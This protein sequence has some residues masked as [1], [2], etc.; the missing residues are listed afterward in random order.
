MIFP[1]GIRHPMPTSASRRKREP[2]KCS[3][4]TNHKVAKYYAFRL[5]G[6]VP[7]K[8][9]LSRLFVFSL[10]ASDANADFSAMNFPGGSSHRGPRVAEVLIMAAVFV[11]GQ[12]LTTQKISG[13]KFRETNE[14]S[15]K[16][17]KYRVLR[18]KG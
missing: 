3:P 5:K 11:F 12:C 4:L 10:R 1:E 6:C 17:A 13:G 16:M 14:R 15:I 8:A 9:L 7:C 2:P 18:L